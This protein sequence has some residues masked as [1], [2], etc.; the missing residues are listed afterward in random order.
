MGHAATTCGLP[1]IIYF[2]PDAIIFADA[3]NIDAV[4]LSIGHDFCIFFF[5]ATGKLAI[6]PNL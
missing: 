3:H 1:E 4:I 5:K 6:S 2:A